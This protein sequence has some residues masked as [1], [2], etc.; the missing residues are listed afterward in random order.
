[1]RPGSVGLDFWR[2]WT[3]HIDVARFRLIDDEDNRLSAAV[4]KSCIG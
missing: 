2:P 1:M 3:R 4:R